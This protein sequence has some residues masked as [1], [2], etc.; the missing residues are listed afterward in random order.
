MS[1]VWYSDEKQL[2]QPTC[3]TSLPMWDRRMEHET[4]AMT[5]SHSTKFTPQGPWG[6]ALGHEGQEKKTPSVENLPHSLDFTPMTSV[7]QAHMDTFICSSFNGSMFK[8]L[9]VCQVW[10]P[11]NTLPHSAGEELGHGEGHMAN[12][13][14]ICK[15]HSLDTNPGLCLQE[16]NERFS[17]SLGIWNWFLTSA[18]ET[19]A[20]STLSASTYSLSHKV[21]SL[22]VLTHAGWNIALRWKQLYDW[23]LL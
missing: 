5:R 22:S 23:C 8:Y 14:V 2:T 16:S 12:A 20:S 19:N 1:K 6:W 11:C 18:P 17:V 4:R 9:T 21:L 10:W 7:N 13:K 15:T 3:P